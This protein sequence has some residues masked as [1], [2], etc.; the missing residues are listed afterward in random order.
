[1]NKQPNTSIPTAWPGRVLYGLITIVLPIASFALAFSGDLGPEWQS[2]RVSDYA[3]LM[4]HG[5]VSLFFAPLLAYAMLSMLLLL[6][7]PE[8]FSSRFAVRFGIYTGALLALQYLLLLGIAFP[9]GIIFM[10]AGVF[11][12]VGLP[13]VYAK[14]TARF[15]AATTWAVLIGVFVALV[16]IWGALTGTITNVVRQ[17]PMLV[18]ITMLASGP[19]WCLLIAARVSL[20]L[21]REHEV[22]HSALAPAGIGAFAWLMGWVNVWRL[23]IAK[24]LE[25]YAALPTSPPDCYIATA[26]AHGHPRFVQT[27]RIIDARGRTMWINPQVRYLKCA[28]LALRA[29]WPAAHRLGRTLYDYLGVRLARRITHPLMADAVY[30]T[31]KPFEWG[32]RAILKLLYPEVVNIAARF[33]ADGC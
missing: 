19:A 11:L 2:G 8:R 33:Y 7:A 3:M 27:E 17:L 15:G 30:V 23:A 22:P 1:M 18:M 12:A 24:A 31:L 25:V 14:L 26:A 21:M 4:L 9:P 20:R 28:E 29:V 16:V 32:A 6:I 5:P 10:G 13:W